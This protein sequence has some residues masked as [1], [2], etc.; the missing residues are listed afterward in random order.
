MRVVHD[1]LRDKLGVTLS[2]QVNTDIVSV[3]ETT[4]RLQRELDNLKYLYGSVG[5]KIEQILEHLTMMCDHNQDLLALPTYLEPKVVKS[6]KRAERQ[7]ASR[8]T[9]KARPHAGPLIE[10][11]VVA[12]MMSR[13]VANCDADLPPMLESTLKVKAP[14]RPQ[15]PTNPTKPKRS[16]RPAAAR[17]AD[18]APEAE[19]ASEP[20]DGSASED[21][22]EPDAEAPPSLQLKAGPCVHYVA[23]LSNPLL[24][25]MKEGDLTA[26]LTHFDVPVPKA[27][28]GR[29]RTKHMREALAKARDDIV[30]EF[31]QWKAKETEQTWQD[32]IR[33][34]SEVLN[35]GLESR[36][37][38]REAEVVCVEPVNRVKE[39]IDPRTGAHV[40]EVEF[41]DHADDADDA[42]DNTHNPDHDHDHNPDHDHDPGRDPDHKVDHSDGYPGEYHPHRDAQ[43]YDDGAPGQG[44]LDSPDGGDWPSDPDAQADDGDDARWQQDEAGGPRTPLHAVDLEPP[45]DACFVGEH[46]AP[47]NQAALADGADY[48]WQ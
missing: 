13:A 32:K 37:R 45:P 1:Q 16:T 11:P 8:S 43:Q 4:E 6:K 35:Q 31:Q 36:A 47:P 41:R 3:R 17:A 48:D 9:R 33:A 39:Y 21:E 30:Q 7:Q 2:R 28:K 19:E 14:A 42:N 24:M 26:A 44:D 15:E 46:D 10:P 29:V 12:E 20:S 38:A 23:Q 22:S 34:A 40:V 27:V 25:K 5:M 18:D